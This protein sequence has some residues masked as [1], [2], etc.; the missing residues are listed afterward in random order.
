MAA[1]ANSDRS[2]LKKNTD[3]EG[4]T[5]VR[6]VLWNNNGG[7]GGR[8]GDVST[9]KKEKKNTRYEDWEMVLAGKGA[10]RDTKIYSRRDVKKKKKL[11]WYYH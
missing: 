8:E 5:D 6:T 2:R 11:G 9:V 4:Q 7:E 3:D 1:L 10:G